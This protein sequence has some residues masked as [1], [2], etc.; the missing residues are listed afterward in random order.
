MS[1][2]PQDNFR[3]FLD[4]ENVGLLHWLLRPSQAR[5]RSQAPPRSQAPRRARQ[6]ERTHHGLDHLLA[7][8]VQA[9]FTGLKLTQTGS[10]IGGGPNVHVPEVISVSAGPPVE[11]DIRTLPGQMADDFTAHAPAIAENLGV[12]EV[13]VVPLGPSLIRLEL[14]PELN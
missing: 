7:R 9:I 3:S 14:L 2:Y 11:V 13:R 6:L 8:R 10:T 5:R 1:R 4:K 12:A